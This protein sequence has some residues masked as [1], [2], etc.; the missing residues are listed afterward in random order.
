M[1][2]NNFPDNATCPLCGGT[3]ENGTT[4]RTI[5]IE[6]AILI[7]KDVPAGICDLCGEEWFMLDVSKQLDELADE[8]RAKGSQLEIL[9]YPANRMAEVA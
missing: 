5:S 1:K 4:T 9:P 6:T 3:I 8:M 7:V 2:R